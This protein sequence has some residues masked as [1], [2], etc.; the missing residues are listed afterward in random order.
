MPRPNVVWNFKGMFC[1]KLYERG[2]KTYFFQIKEVINFTG[3]KKEK[4]K[5]RLISVIIPAN[6]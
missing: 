4:E 5:N 3:K 1:Y 6:C 2:K